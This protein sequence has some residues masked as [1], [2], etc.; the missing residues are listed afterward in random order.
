MNKKRKSAR[1]RFRLDHVIGDDVA[2]LQRKNLAQRFRRRRRV[3]DLRQARRSELGEYRFPA[4]RTNQNGNRTDAFLE[5]NARL[6]TIQ[7]YLTD[8]R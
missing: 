8:G 2:W 5:D 6:V 7:L 1:H 4:F 3:V